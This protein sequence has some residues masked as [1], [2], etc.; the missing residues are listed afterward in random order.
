MTE[1]IRVRAGDVHPGDIVFERV[2]WGKGPNDVKWNQARVLETSRGAAR[3]QFASE[4]QPRTVHFSALW[5]DPCTPVVSGVAVAADDDQY[6]AWLDMGRDL[7][8]S[9]ERERSTLQAEVET[10]QAQVDTLDASHRRRIQ[11]LEAELQDARRTHQEERAF[12]ASR[13][14]QLSKK[15]DANR[16]RYRAMTSMVG[17]KP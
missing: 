10:L 2:V 9:M 7:L 6:A 14:E 12:A 16:E 8:D 13:L 1:R 5:R 17:G 11:D 4:K 15:L 3:V